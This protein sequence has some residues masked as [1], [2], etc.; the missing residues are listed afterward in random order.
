MGIAV[1]HVLRSESRISTHTSN[2]ACPCG[3]PGLSRVFA[4]TG[5]GVA[6]MQGVFL[7]VNFAASGFTC[8]HM[9]SRVRCLIQVF[10]WLPRTMLCSASLRPRSGCCNLVSQVCGHAL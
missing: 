9:C 8:P 5:E 7:V 6:V 1:V 3:Y 2:L 4:P 10:K